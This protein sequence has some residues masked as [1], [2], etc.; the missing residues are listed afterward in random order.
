MFLSSRVRSLVFPSPPIRS[1][2]AHVCAMPRAQSHIPYRNS[3]LTRILQPALGGNSL[4]V[5]ICTITPADIH[6]E[7]TISSLGFASRAKKISNNVKVNEIVDDQTQIKKL[8]QE[9]TQ[10][11]K[12]VATTDG[13]GESLDKEKM[14]EVCVFIACLVATHC[15]RFFMKLAHCIDN[16]LVYVC[17]G[18]HCSFSSRRWKSRAPPIV[19]VWN[20]H[21]KSWAI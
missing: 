1:Q 12:I 8:K 3:K 6:V 7:E 16:L 13:S 2:I 4:T 9:I 14:K 5:I 19:N 11:K 17:W 18:Y 10:L 21:R 20:R 15:S